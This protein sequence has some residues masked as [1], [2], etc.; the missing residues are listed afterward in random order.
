MSSEQQ[1][2]KWVKQPANRLDAWDN[3]GEITYGAPMGFLEKGGDIS[4]ILKDADRS[5]DYFA[6]VRKNLLHPSYTTA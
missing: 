3:I 6:V 4:G 1:R 5:L 2:E